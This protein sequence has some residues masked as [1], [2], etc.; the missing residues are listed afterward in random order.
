VFQIKTDSFAMVIESGTMGKECSCEIKKQPG[1]IKETFLS[2][3][4]WT[5]FKKRHN[6]SFLSP[7]LPE[8]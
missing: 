3:D 7:K 1:Q 5:R 8:R 4:Y 2:E 6:L